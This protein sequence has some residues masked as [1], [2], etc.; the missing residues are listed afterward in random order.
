MIHTYVCQIYTFISDIPMYIRYII[1]RYKDNLHR[2]HH[3]VADPW[4]GSFMMESLTND[5]VEKAMLIINEVTR[6]VI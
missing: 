6:N 2:P 5:I 4:A 3:Q 1:L